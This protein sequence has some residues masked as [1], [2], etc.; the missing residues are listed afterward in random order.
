M[1]QEEQTSKKRSCG[2]DLNASPGNVV[3]CGNT[4]A[5]DGDL[6]IQ[7]AHGVLGQLNDMNNGHKV[8]V[9]IGNF[10]DAGC[11][12]TFTDMDADQS[13]TKIYTEQ[14]DQVEPFN[15]GFWDGVT[16]SSQ[17]DDLYHLPQSLFPPCP[18][19]TNAQ[20]FEIYNRVVASCLYNFPCERIPLASSL[21]AF[22][23]HKYLNIYN[24]PLLLDMVQFGW[25]INYD[26]GNAL[27]STY[28]NHMSA[29]AYPQQLL[30]Y[31]T[32][33]IKEGAL[34]GPFD[35]PLFRYTHLNPLMTK[36]K[37][38]SELRRVIMDLSWPPGNSVNDG[39]PNTSYL[40]GPFSI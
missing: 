2:G 27:V 5:D 34:A 6:Q 11:M 20:V 3:T 22:G 18:V 35:I 24:D 1:Y 9:D 17:P 7:D 28:E 30:H 23:W 25:P 39:I 14:C 40:G 36:P 21:D 29:N 38:D 37:K 31:I 10:D 4:G 16:Q 32:T 15:S 8:S 33:E 26:R 12:E 13:T 19:Q